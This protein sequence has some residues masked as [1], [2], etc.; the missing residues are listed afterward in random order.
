MLAVRGREKQLNGW[1]VPAGPVTLEERSR[2]D[3]PLPR[4]AGQRLLPAGW[5]VLCS[6]R[7]LRL[8]MASGALRLRKPLETKASGTMWSA[9]PSTYV[10]S[11][12]TRVGIYEL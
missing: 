4:Q 7:A 6:R 3:S 9:D 2:E 8:F 1:C 11:A 12:D 5:L 10:A